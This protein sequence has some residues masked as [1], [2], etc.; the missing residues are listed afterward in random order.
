MTRKGR[1]VWNANVISDLHI[2]DTLRNDCDFD[3]ITLN[4]TNSRKVRPKVH[5]CDHH[6]LDIEIKILMKRCSVLDINRVLK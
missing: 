3:S 4:I 6:D 2:N 1:L 5:D